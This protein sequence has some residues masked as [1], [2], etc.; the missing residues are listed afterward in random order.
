MADDKMEEDEYRLD[1]TMSEDE[2]IEYMDKHINESIPKKKK[3][4][5]QNVNNNNNNNDDDQ[6]R[7]SAPYYYRK[8]VIE[9]FIQEDTKGVA[10]IKVLDQNT[11]L[12]KLGN[13]MGFYMWNNAYVHHTPLG[14]KEKDLKEMALRC[15]DFCTGFNNIS[16][17]LALN[18]MNWL[19]CEMQYYEKLGNA[20]E[21]AAYQRI[22][23][24]TDQETLAVARIKSINDLPTT[25]PNPFFLLYSMHVLAIATAYIDGMLQIC[26]DIICAK[27]TNNNAE[28]R[29][30]WRF[31]LLAKHV[32]M[33]SYRQVSRFTQTG[34][35]S[36]VHG[37][38]MYIFHRQLIKYIE[39]SVFFML[40]ASVE[41][42]LPARRS[43]LLGPGRREDSMVPLWKY[44]LA[45][46]HEASS[47][48]A[49]LYDKVKSD[50]KAAFNGAPAALKELARESNR[51]VGPTKD[52]R[53]F[54]SETLETMY[55]E[56]GD[57]VKD[58]RT[59]ELGVNQ[60][61]NATIY[62]YVKDA[63]EKEYGARY[64]TALFVATWSVVCTRYVLESHG[65]TNAVLGI[66]RVFNEPPT[67]LN[68]SVNP[69]TFID[70]IEAITLLCVEDNIRLCR[71]IEKE[72]SGY[73][74]KTYVSPIGDY[75]YPYKSDLTMRM[76][77]AIIDT[78]SLLKENTIINTHWKGYYIIKLNERRAAIDNGV[79]S[80]FVD[81]KH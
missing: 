46:Y 50:F 64:I 43:T 35:L 59:L 32:R 57:T 10:P 36:M 12:A 13:D 2:M 30:Y 81:F 44:L 48:D 8:P 78:Q 75:A 14:T 18:A 22:M 47:I 6:P 31:Y 1:E 60:N 79:I 49:E 62:T 67:K 37:I 80:V 58:V 20:V 23:S 5:E 74:L 61:D 40:P 17:D 21:S 63:Y 65:I 72:R 28:F 3:L 70:V 11:K 71:I 51:K 68:Y 73:E 33:H 29:D 16:S 54:T 66:P 7:K 9:S 45:V 34:T 39:E 52:M 69:E 77:R 76:M 15:V 24:K 56:N 38:S 25:D 41:G 42:N 55:G 19:I 4:N 26:R 53:A 27:M